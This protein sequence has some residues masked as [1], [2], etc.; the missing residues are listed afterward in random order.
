[1]IPRPS[2]I[3]IVFCS[4][5]ALLAAETVTGV[6]RKFY[7][8]R[9]AGYPVAWTKVKPGMTSR[10]A[11]ALLGPPHSAAHRQDLKP[12]DRWELT[13]AGVEMHLDLYFSGEGEDAHIATIAAWKHALG[14]SE[15]KFDDFTIPPW[16]ANP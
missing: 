16:P 10:E 1:M 6:A 8:S 12:L 14:V 11:W 3:L 13:K 5:A 4:L 15:D 9:V 2:R 7:S